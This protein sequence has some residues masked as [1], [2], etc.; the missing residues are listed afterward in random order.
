MQ[1]FSSTGITFQ[2]PDMVTEVEITCGH[3]SISVHIAIV[4]EQNYM[5]SVGVTGSLCNSRC[6][7][8]A[9]HIHNVSYSPTC[10]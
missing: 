5:W 4:T 2:G 8:I 10:E 1:K 9:N 6:V 7:V 3:R